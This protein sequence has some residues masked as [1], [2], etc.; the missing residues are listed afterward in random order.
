M[1]Q[2]DRLDAWGKPLPNPCCRNEC[3]YN[4]KGLCKLR[5]YCNRE[6]IPAECTNYKVERVNESE[7]AA[8]ARFQEKTK[9]KKSNPDEYARF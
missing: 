4:R 5:R 6:I 9:K 7:K 3:L 2:G 1:N 8:N